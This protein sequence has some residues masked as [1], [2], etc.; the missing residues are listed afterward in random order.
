ML[1]NILNTKLISRLSKN[2]RS[3]KN[4]TKNLHIRR[5]TPTH[6]EEIFKF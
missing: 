4:T 1:A 6:P 2:S 5:I 3:T